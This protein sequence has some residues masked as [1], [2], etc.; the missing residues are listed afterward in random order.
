MLP[1]LILTLLAIPAAL[2]ESVWINCAQNPAFDVQA[3]KTS[4]LACDSFCVTYE[5][6]YWKSGTL[7]CR[8]SNSPVPIQDMVGT[9]NLGGS[10]PSDR[11][12]ERKISSQYGTFL[13]C[14]SATNGM[15][16][17]QVFDGI[18]T[19]A[20]CWDKCASVGP[21]TYASY[22]ASGQL[23]CSCFNSFTGTPTN[24]GAGNTY[25]WQYGPNVVVS[26]V[27][28]RRRAVAAAAQ[29]ALAEQLAPHCP[30]GL[31]A[32]RVSPEML[33]HASY[34]CINPLAELES[35]GGC[36][37]GEMG[38]GNATGVDCTALPG[39]SRTGVMCLG[40]RCRAW[41]CENGYALVD[42]ACVVSN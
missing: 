6:A 31:S 32:C 36:V 21:T 33:D 41:Q 24:C 10:C 26:G 40:G 1:L 38:T 39:T 23:E 35:C 19:V 13:Q 8:C 12:N 7:D 42:G 9:T 22:K 4:S 11:Y 30:L 27:A 37:F 20:A 34:E 5:Y 18:P 25:V 16:N 29:K 2:A 28:R 15:V 17:P 3:A 14:L